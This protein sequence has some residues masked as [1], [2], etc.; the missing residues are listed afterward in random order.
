MM[1]IEK[2][3]APAKSLQIFS[4]TPVHVATSETFAI[5]EHVDLSKMYKKSKAVYNFLL[6]LLPCCSKKNVCLE[7]AGR[8]SFIAKDA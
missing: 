8:Q 2:V 3:V 5:S 4:E 1:K 7:M 6:I